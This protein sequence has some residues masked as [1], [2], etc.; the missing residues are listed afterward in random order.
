MHSASLAVPALILPMVKLCDF[1]ECVGPIHNC[2][3]PNDVRLIDNGVDP[4]PL[5]WRIK[6]IR[7]YPSSKGMNEAAA[8]IE[9]TSV[10]NAIR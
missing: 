7:G 5:R 6:L 9:E 1:R 4:R 8:V 2:R 3:A 10:L